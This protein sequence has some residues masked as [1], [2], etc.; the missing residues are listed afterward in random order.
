M[1]K[2]NS[3]FYVKLYSVLLIVVLIPIVGTAANLT[4]TSNPYH[5]DY[6]L[7][8]PAYCANQN[9]CIVDTARLGDTGTQNFIMTKNNNN[10]LIQ[11][12]G[13]IVT[14]EGKCLEVQTQCMN[15]DGCGVQTWNCNGRPEQKW[16]IINYD[17]RPFDN[18]NLLETN[19]IVYIYNVGAGRVLS[20]DHRVYMWPMDDSSKRIW[21]V[22][23]N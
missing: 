17:G 19:E 13:N 6:I 5:T 2:T 20:K 10:A 16:W 14:P 4:F 11:Y 8:V 18:P 3:F 9:G 22:I 23:Q 1:K 21:G 7:T 15:E 12:Y